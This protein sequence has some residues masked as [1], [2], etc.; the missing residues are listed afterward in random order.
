MSCSA[1]SDLNLTQTI[2]TSAPGEVI[3]HGTSQLQR[4]LGNRQLQLIAIGASISTGLFVTIGNGLAR[5]GPGSLFLGVAVYCILIGLVSSSMAE[6]AT[7]MPAPGGF[8]QMASKWVDDALGFMVGWNFFFYE[9]LIIP[10]EITALTMLLSFWSDDIPVGAV[11]AAVIVLYGSG[12]VLLVFILFGFTFVTMV[13]GNSQH[14]AYGFRNWQHGAFA[15]YRT[16]ALAAGEVKRP[17]IFV[18][19]AFKTTFWRFFIFVLGRALCVSIVL[20]HKDAKLQAISA[21]SSEP[22]AAA[23]PYVIAMNN[24]G[25]GTLPHIVNALLITSIFSA[26]NTYTYCAIRSLYGLALA[27]KAPAFLKKMHEERSAD[28]LLR[29]HNAGCLINYVVICITYIFFYRACKAQNVERRSFPY[30]GY[31]QPYAAWVGLA[32]TVF[33]VLFYGYSSFAPWDVAAFFTYYA[34]VQPRSLLISQPSFSG[35]LKKTKPV[36]SHKADLVWER[37]AIVAYEA[38]LVEEPVVRFWTEV[39]QAFG[40]RRFCGRRGME[41]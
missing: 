5:D 22:G 1:Q 27:G 10:F 19:K 25:V 9:G 31:C 41:A 17:Q 34:M 12:K 28:L 16:K 15:E 23:S 29:C 2:S 33:M 30:F 6:M 13:G 26:G 20:S 39:A 35:N 32:G 8:I 14:Y 11:C 4:R 3:D 40:W 21:G 24:L 38:T 18:K 37:P 7:L 36:S